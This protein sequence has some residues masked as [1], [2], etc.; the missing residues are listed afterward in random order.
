MVS[1]GIQMVAQVVVFF[2]AAFI[3]AK[4]TTS[5]I[6]PAFLALSITYCN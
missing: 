6:S 3:I 4:H 1:I 2:T 5:Y